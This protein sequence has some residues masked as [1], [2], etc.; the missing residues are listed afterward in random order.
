[1]MKHGRRSTGTTD[2]RYSYR[3]SARWVSADLFFLR[4]SLEHGMSFAEVA[5][6]LRK[7]ADEVRE[8][9]KELNYHDR[10]I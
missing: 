4:N 6:F 5:G 9:A 1:M 8:K 2:G 3:W 7:T 10:R